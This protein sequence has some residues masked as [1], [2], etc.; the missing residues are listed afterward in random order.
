MRKNKAFL[1]SLL[2][3]ALLFSSV[4]E[5]FALIST[6]S[7]QNRV[8]QRVEETVQEQTQTQEQYSNQGENTQNRIQNKVTQQQQLLQLQQKREEFRERLQQI[9]DLQK[10]KILSNLDKAFTN[11]NQRWTAH[12]SLVLKRLTKILDKVK[13]LAEK[14]DPLQ[15]PKIDALYLQIEEL[16]KKVN[17]QAQKDYIIDLSETEKIGTA[18]REVHSQLREDLQSLREEIK[19]LRDAIHKVIIS[20]SNSQVTIKPTP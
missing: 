14:K 2:V 1:I 18:A 11:I 15:L 12:F 3:F 8:Q 6:P 10:Q 20:L 7:S 16:E 13:I 17:Q 4:P 5:V 19:N 9:K